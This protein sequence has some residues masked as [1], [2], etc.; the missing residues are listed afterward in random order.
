MTIDDLEVNLFDS[1]AVEFSNDLLEQLMKLHGGFNTDAMNEH[2]LF[3][4]GQKDMLGKIIKY[5][6][7]VKP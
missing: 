7:K 3:L 6:I 5:L 2:Q 1:S 4:E